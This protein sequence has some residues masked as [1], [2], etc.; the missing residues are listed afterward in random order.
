M[1]VI[2]YIIVYVCL[3]VFVVAVVA[4]AIVWLRMPLHLR[5]EL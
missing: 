4:R 2:P 1:A 3:A 5:W